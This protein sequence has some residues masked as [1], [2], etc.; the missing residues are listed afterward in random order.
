MVNVEEIREDI[1]SR[2]FYISEDCKGIMV[3]SQNGLN[4]VKPPVEAKRPNTEF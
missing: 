3:G 2:A 4:R 1:E